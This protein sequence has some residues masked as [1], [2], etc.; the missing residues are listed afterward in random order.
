MKLASKLFITILGTALFTSCQ[1]GLV[2]DEVPADVYEDVSLS[3]NL[4]KVETREIFT[5]KVDQVNYKQWV[6]NM[7]LV[8]NI[9]LDYRSNTEYINNTG[10]DVTILGEVIKPGEK[11]MVQ[12][13]LTT[14]DEASAPDG[15]LYVINVFATARATYKT[16][17]KGHVF[18]ES[19]FQGEDIKFST[20]GD[21]EGQYQ[22]A[23]IPVDP[24]KLS[25]ALLLNNSKAC[26]VE[27]VGDAPELGKPGDF[28]KPQRYMV[29]NITRRPEGEPAR[30]LYEVRVQLLK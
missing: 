18:V 24:T 25:V 2:Y 19:E 26:E 11:I 21:N 10:S 1:K 13:K 7:L 23:S 22:E 12:N 4:C 28:S 5:H 8:S 16:P 6:D 27:R 29:V 9:G 17:N 30:R 14:E 3:T 20:P 15:K